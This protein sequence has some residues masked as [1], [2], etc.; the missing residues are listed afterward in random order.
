MG[1]KSERGFSIVE[2]LVVCAVIGIIAS[3]A[4][5][6]LKKG[7]DASQNGN[8]FASMRTLSST[9]VSYYSVNSRFGKL[10][11]LNNL[12][13]GQL[14]TPSGNDLLRGK[15]T[16][17]MVPPAPSDAELKDGYIVLAT[18]DVVGEN[19]VVTYRLTQT[20]EIATDP[21]P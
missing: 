12:L 8:M 16:L 20:G 4:V 7:V 14:G 11:E 10:S 21:A 6:Y 15:F 9:Q 5:P 3:I 13:S 1:K 2:L 17:S 18:R 19:E